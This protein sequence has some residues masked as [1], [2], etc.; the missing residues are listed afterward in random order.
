MT[1][2]HRAICLGCLAVALA[3]CE[4]S[5]PP[6]SGTA[7]SAAAAGTHPP[8][9]PVRASASVAAP[10]VSSAPAVS[11]DDATKWSGAYEAKRAKL[12]TPDKVKDVTWKKD[13]GSTASGEGKLTI[14]VS[15][16]RVEGSATGAL[17]A[18]VISGVY[19]GKELRISFIPKDPAVAGAM[20]GSGVAELKD[21]V[22]KGT[23]Q[24]AGP[25]GVVVRKVTFELKPGG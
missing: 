14:A 13:D 17:G 23:A 2:L 4:K 12:E 5:Q 22:L 6:G 1:K 24:C 3:A 7:S 11:P 8:A 25:D 16:T 18:Q 21:G 15:G 20:T 9:A 19:D 10:A